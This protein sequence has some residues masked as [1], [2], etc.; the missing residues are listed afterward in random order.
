VTEQGRTFLIR[1]SVGTQIASLRFSLVF[2]NPTTIILWHD[3]WTPEKWTPKE[4]I[5]ARQRRGKHLSAA[6][7]KHATTEQQWKRCFICVPVELY[8]SQSRETLKYGH[9][10]RGTR[11]K[12][13][14]WQGPAAVYPNDRELDVGVGGWGTWVALL[15][16][17]TKQRQVKT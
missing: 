2:V 7:I 13:L 15:D 6:K 8:D 5:V 14:C 11:N 3:G 9:Y 17:A 16:T 12:G 10:S 1:I 4:A